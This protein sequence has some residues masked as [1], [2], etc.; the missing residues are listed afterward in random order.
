[1]FYEQRCCVFCSYCY[2]GFILKKEGYVV[3]ANVVRIS[4]PGVNRDGRSSIE[5]T[6]NLR[7][8]KNNNNNYKIIPIITC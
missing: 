1:M 8:D 6:P 5:H 7:L 3:I 2:S 4:Q